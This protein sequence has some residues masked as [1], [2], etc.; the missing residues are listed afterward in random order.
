ML[1]RA[2]RP[3]MHSLRARTSPLKFFA[4]SPAPKPENRRQSHQEWEK[5]Y[6]ND[7]RSNRPVRPSGARS[8]PIQIPNAGGPA[9][10]TPFRTS[11]AMSFRPSL[12]LRQTSPSRSHEEG[13][14]SSALL[15]RRNDV[16]VPISTPVA[17]DPI[18]PFKVGSSSP[19]KGQ[20]LAQAHLSGV[21][22]R[23]LSSATRTSSG[24]YKEREQRLVEKEEARMLREALEVVDQ[25]AEM[26]LHSAAQTEASELVWKH[27]N[28]GAPGKNLDA[29]YLHKQRLWST[30]HGRSQSD[31]LLATIAK[32]E[33]HREHLKR[34][35]SEESKVQPSTMRIDLNP[36]VP[37]ENEHSEALQGQRQ[38]T[39]QAQVSASAETIKQPGLC[40]KTGHAL[41]DSP[42]KKAYLNLSSAIPQ[43]K[44][45]RRRRSSASKARTPSG[46]LFR[47]PDDKIYEEPEGRRQGNDPLEAIS[48]ANS[49]PFTSA[50][51]NPVTKTATASQSYP[52]SLTDPVKSKGNYSRTEIYR[53]PPSQSRNPSYLQNEPIALPPDRAKEGNSHATPNTAKAGVDVRSDDIRAATSMKLRDRSPKLPS[54]TVVSN[55]KGRPI[56]SFDKHWAPKNSGCK[57][58]ESLSRHTSSKDE[59]YRSSSVPRPKP[60]LPAPTASTPAVPTINIPEIP[61]IN[62]DEAPSIPTISV[63]AAPSISI[64]AED[65][66]DLSG[67]Q[68]TAPSR[69]LPTPSRKTVPKSSGRPLPH[70]SFTAPVHTSIPHWSPSQ[71]RATAQCAACALPISGRIVS[72]SSQRFHPDCFTCFHCSEL[73]E[74][75]A[76][77]PEPDAFR[78]DRVVR[79]RARTEGTEVPDEAGK[80]WEDDGDESLRFYCHLD[81]H[82]KFSPRCRSCKTPIEGEVVVAC[83][84]EWHVGHFFCAQCGDPFDPKTPFVEKD[85]YAWCVGCHTNRFSDKCRGCKKPVVDLVECGG[86][87]EDGRFF[88][89]GDDEVPYRYSSPYGLQSVMPVARNGQL[90]ANPFECAKGP[91]TGHDADEVVPPSGQ[92]R[93]Y[94]DQQSM[95]DVWR[96]YDLNR[97][98]CEFRAGPLIF[99]PQMLL[100]RSRLPLAYLDTNGTLDLAQEAR[101]I[102]AS[103]PALEALYSN[104]D[105]EPSPPILIAECNGKSL[106]AI[107]RVR[108]GLYAQ[109]RLGNWVALKDLEER[110]SDTFSTRHS[111]RLCLDKT[112]AWW[113][114]VIANDKGKAPYAKK[115]TIE[116]HPVKV[117]NLARPKYV[118]MKQAIPRKEVPQVQAIGL[119]NVVTIDSEAIS[120]QELPQ[121]PNERPSQDPEGLLV[122]IKFQYM[123]SLYRSMASLA[124]FAKGPLSRARAAFSDS[125]SRAASPY[126]LVDYLR[127]LIIPLNLLDKK[128]RET[129]PALVTVFTSSIMSEGEG[130]TVAAKLRKGD[131]KSK[132]DKL[133]KNGLY[134]CEEAEI[135]KWWL[136][137]LVTLHA[138]EPAQLR[139]EATKTRLL[140]QRAREIY[141]QMIL[142]LEVLALESNLP[143]PSVEKVLDENDESQQPQKKPKPKKKQDLNM[144]LDLSIDKLC[145]WQSMATEE[146]K[147]VEESAKT[148][149]THTGD[150]SSKKPEMD[151]LRDFCVDVVLPFYASRVP[152]VSNAMCKKLGGPLPH[153]PARP[154]LRKAATSLSRSQKPGAPVRKPQAG[155][156]RRT[157][158]RVLTAERISRRPTP[159]LSRSATDS[160]L[161]SLKR[162]TSDVSLSSVPLNK[163]S[164]HK[165][166]R[167]S[168]REVDL[169]G[170]AQAIEAKAK[171]KAIVEHELRGAIAALK[172]PNPRMA[173]KE[174]V[175]ASEKRVAGTKSR[176]SKKPVRN[177]FAQG[178]QIAATPSANRR[179]DVFSGLHSQSL[180]AAAVQEELEEIPSSSCALVPASTMKAR[181]DEI[182]GRQLDTTL[183][184]LMPSVEQ[185]PTRGPSKFA[186]VDIAAK[187]RLAPESIE[188]TPSSI[189]RA[190]YAMSVQDTCQKPGYLKPTWTTDV[191][192]TPSRKASIAGLDG[193]LPRPDVESTPMKQL[194]CV[195]TK[196]PRASYDLAPSPAPDEGDESIYTSLGWDDDVDELM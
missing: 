89:R 148:E 26:R 109:Y 177:P 108:S 21:T 180:Q 19:D 2:R 92:K 174:F 130:I 99:T 6:L 151:P 25:E 11:S 190:K 46:S 100:P 31:V 81:F 57:A 133:A 186:Q 101:L 124:Y 182:M 23:D 110:S 160:F 183:Q 178:V 132:K 50:T 82:E 48:D 113:Q 152:E 193:N 7:L 158:E 93:K 126:L 141:L 44:L 63:S 10:E 105:A 191:Q 17:S 37:A 144:L 39:E 153:S 55:A 111:K 128:Y 18:R 194:K 62:I 143:V 35:A 96:R 13:R 149:L 140:Q 68:K 76:F 73:L 51:R 129:L 12:P 1:Q 52:R 16:V 29:P 88:T 38:S 75:V 79:I 84:G 117:L 67:A 74:C 77:Y 112:D 122:S 95:S 86:S 125:N 176:K 119:V 161:P 185:T 36:G 22:A 192:A 56:V 137:W 168:Q 102:S 30:S 184:R 83:G 166:N 195:S 40:T 61:S 115:Q 123:E 24:V 42:Q 164:F 20:P 150:L 94:F 47:N 127:T 91:S 97:P 71:R 118:A 145:I 196:I 8:P 59:A 66:S 171:K 72:A 181:T 173:V 179:R 65:P 33:E 3:S 106:H 34:S 27:Q 139:N 120:M 138:C 167:Y 69:P 114:G 58:Q 53:N 172:R 175:E 165:S 162:E 169:S 146:K 85:G 142:I 4:S 188:S 5:E 43:L 90:S 157:L 54:P 103:I 121:L 170:A 9:S 28:H 104:S 163:S 32:S 135:Q 80:S 15:H 45:S 187:L 134:T 156:A 14:C 87:F 189:A 60:A 49:V 116:G 98:G 70:H 107:E 131:R 147:A 154:A 64:S 155:E 78:D 159:A 41:W 136:D